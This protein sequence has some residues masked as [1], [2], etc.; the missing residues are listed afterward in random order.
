MLI[1]V[2]DQREFAVVTALDNGCKFNAG[3]YVSE[4]LT[5]LSEWW[6]ERGGGNFGTLIVHADNARPHKAVVSYQFMAG[7]AMVITAH[8]RYSPNLAPSDFYLL[9]HVRGLPR[10]TSFEAGQRLLSAVEGISGSF[11]KW[12]LTKVC[13]EWMRRLERCI[14]INGDYVG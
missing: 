6:R 11:E 3:Y 1:I 13:L 9:G 2:W 8:P 12:T 7:N 5:P 10:G 14:E 4:V